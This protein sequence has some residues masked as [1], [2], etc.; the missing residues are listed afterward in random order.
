LSGELHVD[1]LI[2][3][4][5]MARTRNA[6]ERML[7]SGSHGQRRRHMRFYILALVLG[8][9]LCVGIGAVL[10]TLNLQGRI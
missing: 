2:E 1:A 7:F 9:F 8:L 5:F 4:L 3:I 6:L 10:Y